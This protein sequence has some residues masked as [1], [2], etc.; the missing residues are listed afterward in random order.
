MQEAN[1][2]DRLVIMVA[3]RVAA[4]WTV[5]EIIGD[6]TAVQVDTDAW[7]QAFN[8]LT[9][10]HM[11]VLLAGRSVRVPD[12]PAADVR[13]ALDAAGIS[14]RISDVPSTLDETLITLIQT[15]SG[16]GSQARHDQTG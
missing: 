1:Q 5:R 15:T 8:A 13:R 12:T 14:A 9:A 7:E 2:C 6:T 11:I 16:D 10:A 4:A 3:G